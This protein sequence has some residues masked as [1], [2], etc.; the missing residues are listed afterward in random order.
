MLIFCFLS[1][2]IYAEVNNPIKK[3]ALK[4]SIQAE[5]SFKKQ[6]Q[7]Y[8]FASLRKLGDVEIANENEDITLSVIATQLL[9]ENKTT[10]NDI[11]TPFVAIA[12][13]LITSKVVTPYL[14]TGNIDELS[15]LCNQI[16]VNID[17]KCFETLRKG[18]NE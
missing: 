10:G 8:L 3:I 15:N 6:I 1:N 5:E 14:T 12:Y 17:T 16:V 11:E 9:L 7:S 2:Y 18:S 4:V 13:T